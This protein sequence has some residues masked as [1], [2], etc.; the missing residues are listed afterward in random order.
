[1]TSAADLFR[2][3]RIGQLPSSGVVEVNQLAR[4]LETTFL[5]R[6][7]LE[8]KLQQAADYDP[9]MGIMSRG[10]FDEQ[11]RHAI[12]E[13]K[14]LGG[15]ILLFIDLDRFKQVNDT[16]GHAAGDEVL[17]VVAARIRSHVRK[18]DL[19]GRRGGDELTVL[20][21]RV[22]IIVALRIAHELL[23]A[24]SQSIEIPDVG[25]VSIGASI[26][27]AQFPEDGSTFD[28]LVAAAD[29]AMYVAKCE[30][31]SRVVC[32]SHKELPSG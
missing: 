11:A 14:G 9:L 17:K 8:R 20:L 31:R 30:G 2:R 23:Q 29:Q 26:G 1:M 21:T 15:A 12:G 4:A 28:E 27:L 18:T 16:H 24:I 22:D 5:E 25:P 6:R 3:G 13:S 32:A 10:H 7:A 19:V